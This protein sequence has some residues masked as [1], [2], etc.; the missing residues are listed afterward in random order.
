MPLKFALFICAFFEA[1]KIICELSICDDVTKGEKK[2]EKWA[3]A[4]NRKNLQNL[5]VSKT[6][7]LNLTHKT[8]KSS[9]INS[10]EER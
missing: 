6:E 8:A 9:N 10:V 7:N 3:N 1:N 5:V 4:K 2:R